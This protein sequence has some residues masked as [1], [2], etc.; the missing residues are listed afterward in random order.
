MNQILY[1]RKK[2]KKAQRIAIALGAL[3]MLAILVSVI[4]Y[5]IN[6]NN[7]KILSGVYVNDVYAG[8]LTTEEATLKLN[9]EIS[10]LRAKEITL[11]LDKTEF[12]YTY[13]DLGLSYE[14]TLVNRAYE[15]G[16]SGNIIAD[17]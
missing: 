9:E 8:G 2:E 3:F 12:K 11:K 15:Y 10:K 14:K 13:N 6:I 1:S 4:F 16:R 17:N 7:E 5:I